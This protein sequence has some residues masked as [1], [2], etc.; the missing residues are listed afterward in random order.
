MIGPPEGLDGV[1][2]LVVVGCLGGTSSV[3]VSDPSSSA[4][5][6]DMIYY[7]LFIIYYGRIRTVFI[8]IVFAIKRGVKVKL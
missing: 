6:D 4:I 7:C 1:E 8:E 2:M 5:D 3:E